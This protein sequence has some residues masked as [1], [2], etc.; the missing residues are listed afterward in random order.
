MPAPAVFGETPSSF[1][2]GRF[3]RSGEPFGESPEGAGEPFGELLPSGDRTEGEE[4][5]L[6]R[7]TG[8]LVFFG[9][10]IVLR[11]AVRYREDPPN[12]DRYS[13]LEKMDEEIANRFRGSKLLCASS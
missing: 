1:A 2:A 12:K 13:C 8:D 10:G 11:S 6:S 4:V 7:T 9:E 5:L 3:F